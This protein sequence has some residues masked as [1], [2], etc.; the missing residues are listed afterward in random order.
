MCLRQARRCPL[1][2]QLQQTSRYSDVLNRQI[3]PKQFPENEES[4]RRPRTA[5]PDSDYSK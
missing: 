4:L 1:C 5:N 2:L 3:Y